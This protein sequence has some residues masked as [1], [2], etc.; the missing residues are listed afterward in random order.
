[1][2][3]TIMAGDLKFATAEFNF[4]DF[5]EYPGYS[6][7]KGPMDG[8]GLNGEEKCDEESSSLKEVDFSTAEFLPC[9]N[10]LSAEDNLI[11]Y[12]R[13][14]GRIFCGVNASA[15]IWQD[16][17]RNYRKSG[18]E[19]LY[20]IHG[21]EEMVLGGNIIRSPEGQPCIWRFYRCKVDGY[22]VHEGCWVYDYHSLWVPFLKGTV[23]LTVNC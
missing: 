1:M 20:K 18:L 13:K 4:K 14:P 10:E 9:S 7:W 22:N 16:Y 23:L 11:C 12:H 6:F 15:G 19:S 8:D 17:C 2:N 3:Q 5:F 21:F